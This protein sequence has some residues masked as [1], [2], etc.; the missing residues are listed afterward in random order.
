[1]AGMFYTL[2]EVVEKLGK[3]ESQVQDLIRD[4][5]LREFRDGAKLLFKVSEVEELTANMDELSGAKEDSFVELLPEEETYHAPS[6][7]GGIDEDFLN[8]LTSTQIN[9]AED[10]QEESADDSLKIAE[11]QMPPEDSLQIAETQI[12]SDD[13][14]KIA[15]TQMPPEDSLR[16]A[17]TQIPSDDSL[18]IAETQLSDDTLGAAAA[19]LPQGGDDSFFASLSETLP[20]LAQEKGQISDDFDLEPEDAA[21]PSGT[22]ED[23]IVLESFED[24]GVEPGAASDADVMANLTSADTNAGTTGV[25]VLA[26]SENDFIVADDTKGETQLVETGADSGLGDLDNDLNLDSVGSGSGLLD[27]S[28]QADDTSLG[29]VLDDIL[30]AADEAEAG[31]IGMAVE[32]GAGISEEADKI[33]EEAAPEQVIMQPGGYNAPAAMPR[34]V[35]APPDAVSNACGVALLLPLIAVIY[36]VIVLINA[37]FGTSPA[38]LEMVEEYIWYVAGGLAVM[39]LLIIGIAAAMGGSK[40]SAKSAPKVKKK[41][42]KKPK[43]AKK[44]KK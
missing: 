42:E 1:M 2:Q 11:T 16:I 23:S 30:P 36:A 31:G 3:S 37:T 40:G 34:Y 44:M 9:P 41:K 14:L 18:K 43:K 10:F 21:S 8:S 19:N 35:E 22:Q 13:S 32:E 4:G 33:F 28:L 24:Q 12:P 20:G 27:L 5:K 7:S 39:V 17:E 6:D 38:L 25:N 29:A 15:E 26:E